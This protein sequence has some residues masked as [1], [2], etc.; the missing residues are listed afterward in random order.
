[1][2]KSKMFGLALAAAAL[3]FTITAG[4]WKSEVS[5][6]AGVVSEWLVRGA[7]SI[8]DSETA[9]FIASWVAKEKDS[10]RDS[11][12]ARLVTGW[13]VSGTDAVQNV[14]TST[15]PRT[16]THPW[17]D[18]ST[19]HQELQPLTQDIQ[20]ARSIPLTQP[21]PAPEARGDEASAAP[22]VAR[23]PEETRP[24]ETSA[25]P[26]AAPV[27]EETRRDEVP[28]APAVALAPE[29]TRPDE[30]S[31]PAAPPTATRRGLRSNEGAAYMALARSKIQQGD[32]AAARRLLERASDSDK[33]EAWFAL[34]ETYDPQMLARWGVL[35]VK[36]DPEKAR[37][38]YQTAEAR[39]TQG[40]RE[41]LLALRK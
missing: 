10:I 2:R 11:Y 29:E 15:H 30:T 8:R 12:L 22:D 36:P 9:H 17:T 13:I 5:K 34:A 28:A 20:R 31:A 26:A 23:A 27:S 1:M 3:V 7:S 16:S 18:A 41:R 24:D 14:L 37:T 6:T 25:A 35:G 19:S 21:E 39:G 40:A 33:A 4:Q 32:I 38:L